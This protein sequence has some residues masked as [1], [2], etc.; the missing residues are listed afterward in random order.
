MS[1]DENVEDAHD[2]SSGSQK[3]YEDLH[4]Y[5]INLLAVSENSEDER[6]SIDD[7]DEI[8]RRTEA[9][10]DLKTQEQVQKSLLKATGLSK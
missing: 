2:E 6:M 3:E 4:R 10:A 7:V 8:L 1:D 5:L 9:Y